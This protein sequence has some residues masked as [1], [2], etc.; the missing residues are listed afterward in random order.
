MGVVRDL[1]QMVIDC[2][3]PGKRKNTGDKS[4]EQFL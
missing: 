2:T 3:M 1:G 4:A